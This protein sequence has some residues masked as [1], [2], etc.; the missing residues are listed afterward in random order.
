[1]GR[2]LGDHARPG[3]MRVLSNSVRISVGL[4]ALTRARNLHLPRPDM[5]RAPFGKIILVIFFF[6]VSLYLPGPL[7]PLY[8]VDRLHLTDREISLGNA[9]FFGA[10]F[11]VSTQLSRI[12]QRRGHQRVMIMGALVLSTYPVITGLMKEVSVF[13]ANSVIGGVG[14]SLAGGAVNNYVLE[15]IP[16]GDR[17]GYLAWY[18]LT[19]NAAI[20]LSSL[21]APILVQQ[22]GLVSALLVSGGVRLLAALSIWRWGRSQPA[23]G[24]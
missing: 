12:T 5:L 16:A 11:L 14:W 17:R 15:N 23:N 6:H 22:A 4:R 3:V 21:A 24:R 7:Y 2:T 10:V 13:L 9:L 20:L 18:N 1:M 8:W 19:L